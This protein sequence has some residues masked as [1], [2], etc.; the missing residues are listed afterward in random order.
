MFKSTRLCTGCLLTILH[1]YNQRTHEQVLCL[2]DHSHYLQ[3]EIDRPKFEFKFWIQSRVSVTRIPIHNPIT[4]DIIQTIHRRSSCG[5]RFESKLNLC[6]TKR[7]VNIHDLYFFFKTSFI[8]EVKTKDEN[9][10]PEAFR[11]INSVPCQRLMG[12]D[13]WTDGTGYVVDKVAWADG[14]N[15]PTPWTGNVNTF[16][17]N[18]GKIGLNFGNDKANFICQYDIPTSVSDNLIH[19]GIFGGRKRSLF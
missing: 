14:Y 7:S 16:I 15:T 13:W 3:G 2:Q 18:E 4:I 8:F 17:N 19:T 1:W 6:L 9:G 12:G 10:E 11:T 5:K